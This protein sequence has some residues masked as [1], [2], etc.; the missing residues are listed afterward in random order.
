[1]ADVARQTITVN[2]SPEHCFAVVTDFERYP[3]WAKDVKEAL[4]RSRDEQ[5]EKAAS[6]R[7]PAS[8]CLPP[9]VGRHTAGRVRSSTPPR[10]K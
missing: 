4:V 5:G 2:A 3:E 8:V 10:R 6:L 7:R 1:M 9:R